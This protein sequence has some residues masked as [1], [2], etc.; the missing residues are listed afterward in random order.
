[1]AGIFGVDVLMEAYQRGLIP[2][3]K[4]A[5]GAGA[6]GQV[7]AAMEAGGTKLRGFIE[8]IEF[9]EAPVGMTNKSIVMLRDGDNRTR[10]VV[11]K[12]NVRSRLMPG[13]NVELIYKPEE[14]A[15][16]LVEWQYR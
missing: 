7:A 15:N 5:A 11:L 6:T 10:M 4:P 13:R 8:S 3:L 1:M 9:Y 14:D 12:G 2:G 16:A